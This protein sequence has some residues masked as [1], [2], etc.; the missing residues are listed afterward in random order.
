MNESQPTSQA[1]QSQPPQNAQP[2]APPPYYTAAD[3]AL[4]SQD[5]GWGAYEKFLGPKGYAQFKANVC[6][7]ISHQIGQDQKKAQA[8]SDELKKSTTGEE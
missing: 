1:P 2:S 4:A 3:S 5:S 7:A 6:N 8:A